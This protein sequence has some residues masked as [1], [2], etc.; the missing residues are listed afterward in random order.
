[1][2]KTIL[3]G[4]IY[5]YEHIILGKILVRTFKL[6]HLFGLWILKIT[7]FNK[8]P[9]SEIKTKYKDSSKPYFFGFGIV[10]ISIYAII[11]IR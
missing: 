7:T 9:I 5:F 8:K 4:I 11:K 6:I 1:M 10:I 2:I 3:L